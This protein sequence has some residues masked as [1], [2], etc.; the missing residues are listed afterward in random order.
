VY[1]IALPTGLSAMG[2]W[3]LLP[4]FNHFSVLL[5]D[6]GYKRLIN[7]ESKCNNWILSATA[8]VVDIR[9]YRFVACTA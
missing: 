1:I 9:Q 3:E 7:E 2:L 8:L 4:L 5:N 6:Y